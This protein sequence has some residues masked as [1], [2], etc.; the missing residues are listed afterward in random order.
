ML[1]RPAGYLN[2][3]GF[4]LK[5]S[6]DENLAQ[7]FYC[8]LVSS[9]N[10]DSCEVSKKKVIFAVGELIA[11]EKRYIYMNQGTH[12]DCAHFRISLIFD[13]ATVSKR[14]RVEC[15]MIR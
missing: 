15:Q 10:M 5:R 7:C 8:C 9:E 2:I 1:N 13:N 11:V 3:P 12:V 14:I 6:E 4:Q